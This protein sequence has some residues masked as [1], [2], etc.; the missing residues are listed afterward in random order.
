MKSIHDSCILKLCLCL[1]ITYM[2]A[3]VLSHFYVMESHFFYY[4]ARLEYG[5]FL[6]HHSSLARLPFL[7]MVAYYLEHMIIMFSIR[8]VC[9]LARYSSKITSGNSE[10]T[11]ISVNSCL[12]FTLIWKWKFF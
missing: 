2:Y 7:C 6:S 3:L 12:F 4:L 1:V 8:L 5:L 11:I 9:T 10:T